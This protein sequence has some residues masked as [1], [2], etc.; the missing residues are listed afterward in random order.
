[1][2]AL[3][4][5]FALILPSDLKLLPLAR[6]FVEG[7]CHFCHCDPCF[8][9]SVQLAIHEALQNAIRHAHGGRCDATVE[10]QALPLEDGLELR[11]LD[12]GDPFDVSSVPHLDPGEM[13]IGGRGVY[14]IRRLV[15]DLSSEP[16]QPRGN[17]LRM[18]KYYRPQLRRHPA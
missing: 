15:D 14:L 17:V 1:M 18:V 4:R 9:E 10:I 2:N 16:R 12:D 6:A 11:L 5:P 8:A 13:R 7:V 3:P